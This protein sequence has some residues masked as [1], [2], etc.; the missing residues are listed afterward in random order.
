MYANASNARGERDELRVLPSGEEVPEAESTEVTKST[1]ETLMAGERILEA[2]ELA[3]IDRLAMRAYEDEVALAPNAEAAKRVPY[4]TRNAVFA[5]YNN[6]SADEYVLKI[7]KGIPA[8]QLQDALLVLPFGRVTQLIEHIDVWAHRVRLLLS[9]FSFSPLVPLS[10]TLSLTHNIVRRA[11]NSPSRRASSS[12]SCARTTRRSSRRAPCARPWS[13]SRVT[14]ASRSR[15][16]RC[17][18]SPSLPPSPSSSSSSPTDAAHA[19][20][21]A[22]HARVQPRRAQV[23]RAPARGQQGGRLLRAGHARL[24]ARCGHGERGERA[25]DDRAGSEEAQA[26]C[27]EDVDF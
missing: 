17:V 22:E 19:P 14:C 23:P 16:R 11:G 4:P 27:H 2:L 18:L 3:E 13:S 8:A 15:S 6:V 1:T 7:V 25:R 26:G 21:L 12:S 20:P 24:G 5:M 10:L 9:S